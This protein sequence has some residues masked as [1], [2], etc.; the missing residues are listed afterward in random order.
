MNVKG[1]VISAVK[2]GSGK[3]TAA[4]AVMRALKKI[5]FQPVPF[6]VGPDFIDPSHYKAVCGISGRNLDSFMMEKDFMRWNILDAVSEAGG[7][8]N[9]LVLEGVMGLFD[10]YGED[11]RGSTAEIAK[12]LKLPVVLVVDVKGMGQ[13]LQA[14]IHG[15]KSFDK[16]I[17]LAGVILN[18]VGS[19]RHEKLL[20]SLIKK[21]GLKL[22]GVIKKDEQLKIEERHLG[23]KMGYEV[24]ED[25]LKAIDR[26]SEGINIRALLETAEKG[27]DI[28]SKRLSFKK[29]DIRIYIARDE[30]FSFCYRENIRVLESLGEVRFFSPIRDKKLEAPDFIYLPGGYPELF[31]EGLSDNRSMMSCIKDHVERGGFLLA[32]CGGFIYLCKTLN[33]DGKLFNFCGVFPFEMEMGTRYSSLGYVEVE[34]E[35]NPIFGSSKLKGHRFHYSYIKNPDLSVQKT[36]LLKR[37]DEILKEGYTYKNAVGSYVHLHFGSNISAIKVALKTLSGGK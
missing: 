34:A 28:D 21:S 23:I 25:T 11:G 9:F 32:E 14:L 33:T 5:G 36:Y 19:E 3:T 17:N 37:Y 6:K 35:N 20:S 30:A 1:I 7:K 12:I 27:A 13:S 2:S 10:G 18:N 8:N 4:L 26:A 29:S 24:G 31:G 16:K 15:F 22:V